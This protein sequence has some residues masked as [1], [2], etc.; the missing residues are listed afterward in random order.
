MIT[1]RPIEA[2]DDREVARIIRM[3]LEAFG[4]TGPDTAYA[5]PEV[6]FMFEAYAAPRHRYFVAEKDGQVLG[7]VGF[8]PLTGDETG[9]VCELR[10]MYLAPEARGQGIGRQLLE[11]ALGGAREAGFATCYIE[12]MAHMTQAR[13]LY[14]ANGFALLTEALGHTG[15]TSCNT[16]YAR[17]L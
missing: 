8:G 1:I 14:E 11:A 12:T 3:T 17:P 9:T 4:V 10:K 5:D 2:H 15:H 7:G 16:R 13:R 6:D